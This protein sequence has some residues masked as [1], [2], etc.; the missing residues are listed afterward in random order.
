MIRLVVSEMPEALASSGHAQGRSR[1]VANGILPIGSDIS[2]VSAVSD[3]SAVV[4]ANATVGIEDIPSGF[5][6]AS[7]A[8]AVI[9][10]GLS[11]MSV[12]LPRLSG[13]TDP[14]SVQM[15]QNASGLSDISAQRRRASSGTA[16]A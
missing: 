7:S 16:P 1:T 9:A 15:T 11:D 8:T 13:A 14:A 5:P 2:E 10:S 4:C 12:P 3:A 6:Y